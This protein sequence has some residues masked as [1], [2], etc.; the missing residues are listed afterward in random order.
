M[1]AEVS[2]M[3][4]H[5]VTVAW[6]KRGHSE[7]HLCRDVFTGFAEELIPL[8]LAQTCRFSIVLPNVIVNLLLP[9]HLR[10]HI[11]PHV[12]FILHRCSRNPL[13]WII[14]TGPTNGTRW[15]LEPRTL[16]WWFIRSFK[17]SFSCLIVRLSLRSG[18]VRKL[19]LLIRTVHRM[20]RIENSHIL[21]IFF[22]F[23]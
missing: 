22:H 12:F 19:L 2:K 5:S 8:F 10:I 20:V 16:C 13:S 1:T 15:I 11:S 6:R 18:T 17:C 3:A 21:H 14:H 4:A 7:S 9:Q 23:T